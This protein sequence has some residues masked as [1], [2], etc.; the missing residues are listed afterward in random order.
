M[1]NLYNLLEQPADATAA[2][3]EGFTVA[4]L[5]DELVKYLTACG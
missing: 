2:E 3:Q 4:L 1:T 5:R